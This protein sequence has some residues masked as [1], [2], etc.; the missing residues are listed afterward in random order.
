[1]IKAWRESAPAIFASGA[2]VIV[3][4]LCLMFSELNSNKSLGPVA[5][6]GIGCTLLVMMSFLPVALAGV[7]RWVFWPRRP[8]PAT[9]APEPGTAGIWGRISQT[10]GAHPRR[11]WISASVLLLLCLIGIGGLK[12]NGLSTAPGFTNTPDAVV[13]QN[14]Y[15][16]KFDRGVGAPAVIA[17]NA[18]Q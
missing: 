6:I 7:G 17:V 4:L 2:T 11:A 16:A 12:T 10:I 5:A 9:P 13:G 14:I 18:A 15:D 8:T 1:M 3:G